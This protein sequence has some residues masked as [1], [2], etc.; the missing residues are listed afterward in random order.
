M[1]PKASET[2]GPTQPFGWHALDAASVLDKLGSDARN[3]LSAIQGRRRLRRY[4]ANLPVLLAPRPVF[5]WREVHL[6]LL[7][8]PLAAGAGLALR[9]DWAGGAA[10]L[11][12]PL[13]HLAAHLLFSLIGENHRRRLRRR[14]SSPGL[15]VRDG[16]LM[17]IDSPQ[18][19]PGDLLSLEP[20]A[21]IWADARL[22]EAGDLT[23]D[24]SFGGGRS[25]VAKNAAPIDIETDPASQSCMLWCGTRVVEGRGLA[26]VVATGPETS[27]SR[28]LTPV[29]SGTG[30][31]WTMP[32][33]AVLLILWW[34][35]GVLPE[36]VVGI[37][38]V[39]AVLLMG[40]DR[41][42]HHRA[43]RRRLNALE[44]RFG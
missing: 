21:R 36:P 25:A 43:E 26:V 14:W 40:A 7:L 11:C 8:L 23:V 32:A 29:P 39:L 19:V 30:S 1:D 42:G 34:I 33:L 9:G 16:R 41:W 38:P 6:G 10:L 18:L 24:E 31:G 20:G 28:A 15:A 2:A 3:G 27:W 12:L 22:L 4:G 17:P 5:G 13:I 44:S 35:R 37:V